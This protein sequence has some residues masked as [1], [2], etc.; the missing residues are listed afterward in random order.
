MIVF[1]VCVRVSEGTT[2]KHCRCTLYFVDMFCL[3]LKDNV[4]VLE[5]SLNCSAAQ[6]LYL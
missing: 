2:N 5:K 3:C 1:C 4:V 6:L